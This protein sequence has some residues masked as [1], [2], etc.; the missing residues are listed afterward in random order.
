[1]QTHFSEA[2]LRDPKTRQANAILRS[3]VHCG[4]CTATCPTYQLLGDE[5]DSPRGRIYQIKEMLEK[6]EIPTDDTVLHLDRCLSCLACTTTCPSDVDYMHL[7]DHAR[8]YIAENYRR[9]WQDR[10]LRHLLLS[11]LPHPTRFRLVLAMAKL[12]RPLRFLVPDARLRAML[13][14]A[15]VNIAPKSR[16]ETPNVFSPQKKKRLRVALLAGCA[17][18][19][20]NDNI[21][22]ATVRLLT[23]MG[24]EVVVVK[25]VGCCGA[26]AHHL[27]S[28]QDSV[29]AAGRNVDAWQQE[30]R[31]RGLDAILVNTSGCGTMLKDYDHVLMGT[32]WAEAGR[33]IAEKVRDV[34]EI[35]AELGLPRASVATG[36]RVAYHSACSLQHGQQI[37]ELPQE[38]LR[39]AG[40]Q[41]VL[42]QESHLCCG[43]AGTY[44][45]LQPEIS[46]RLMQ[47]KADH[48]HATQPEVI[49][50][51]NVGCMVQIGQAT[52]VP[53]VHTVELL[54]WATGGLV[55]FVLQEGI[56][57]V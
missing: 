51:G 44:N 39:R 24:C 46:R 56:K 10:A 31:E 4:L 54:D 26:L 53:I 30:I 43:S 18:P 3:C 45:L 55:P 9:P 19:V 13:K 27:G 7:I 40:F 37:T 33:E 50:A 35:I 5:R 48:L 12:L 1:M 57:G 41:V 32:P 8:A 23:R 22:A 36:M 11:I 17:Q 52:D 6:K 42:P 14:M 20:L 38:L 29:R 21:H 25:G 34:S 2:Q 28:E 47:R 16:E 49:A 15:R